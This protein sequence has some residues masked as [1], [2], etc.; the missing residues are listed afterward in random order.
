MTAADGTITAT[1]I[2]RDASAGTLQVLGTVASV[3]R[4]RTRS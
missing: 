3:D 2:E 1:R 4:Q